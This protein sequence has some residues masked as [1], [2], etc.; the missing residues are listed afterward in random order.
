MKTFHTHLSVSG[1]RP[2][3]LRRQVLCKLKTSYQF[4]HESARH[5]LDRC[6]LPLSLE[7][8]AAFS[9]L[10]VVL[11]LVLFQLCVLWKSWCLF[12]LFLNIVCLLPQMHIYGNVDLHFAEGSLHDEYMYGGQKVW[13]PLLSERATRNV[14]LCSYPFILFKPFVK[15]LIQETEWSVWYFYCL[16]GKKKRFFCIY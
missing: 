5:H 15:T 1:I 4:A 10:C 14:D 12:M 9:C 2:M 3:P 8:Q 7:D 11:S 13:N 16:Q 6:Y